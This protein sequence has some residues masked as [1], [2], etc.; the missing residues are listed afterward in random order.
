MASA[1]VK[2]T[3]K[4]N[5]VVVFSK[6][7]CPYCVKAKRALQQ[8]TTNFHVVELDQR[9]D[10]DAIQDALLDLTGARS[11]PRVFVAGKFIGGGDDTAAKAASGELK[12]L[13][14]DV[15]AL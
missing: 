10:G 8:L 5:K 4:A 15:G 3:I 1:F 14:A 12:T 9:G 7:Y 13:L 11:V 2:D 6:T